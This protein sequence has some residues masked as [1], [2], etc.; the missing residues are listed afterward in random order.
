[1]TETGIKE[2]DGLLGTLEKIFTDAGGRKPQDYSAI[3]KMV[4]G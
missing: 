2:Y 3:E 4:G 1:V